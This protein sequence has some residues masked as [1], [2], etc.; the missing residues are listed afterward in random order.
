MFERYTVSQDEAALGD[1]KAAA[2]KLVAAKLSLLEAQLGSR[3]FIVGDRRS[4]VDA[5]ATPM[6]RWAANVLPEGLTAYPSLSRH[7]SV[8]LADE[9]V[10]RAMAA[11]GLPT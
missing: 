2:A 11:E 6:L 3:D 9:G 8:M 1:V 4:I 10:K 5:Y 7:Q